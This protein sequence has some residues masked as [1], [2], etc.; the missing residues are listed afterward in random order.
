MTL[1]QSAS[2]FFKAIHQVG[3]DA[4]GHNRFGFKIDISFTV[5]P[6]D[7][8]TAKNINAQIQAALNNARTSVMG[9]NEGGK[10][11]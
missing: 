8:D 7:A 5:A 3:I 4:L 10:L 2:A 1:E 6:D 11:P 9:T